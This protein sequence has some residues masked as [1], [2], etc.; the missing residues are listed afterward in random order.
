MELR[1][2]P[3]AASDRL[4]RSSWC[5]APGAFVSSPHV[6]G[7]SPGRFFSRRAASRWPSPQQGPYVENHSISMRSDMKNKLA[8]LLWA[9]TPQRPELCTLPFVYAAVAAAMDCEVEVHFT[10]SSVR[11]LAEG[12][13]ARI[14]AAA[15]TDKTIYDFMQEAA[16]QGATFLGCSMAQKEHLGAGEKMIAEFSGTAGAATFIMRSLDPEWRVLTF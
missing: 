16:G 4:R 1:R 2:C 3:R 12:V 9:A 11:L 10:G 15:A 6:I 13:A 8:I 5:A 7:P 14:V